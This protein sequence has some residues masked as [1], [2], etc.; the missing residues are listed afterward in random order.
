M[1]LLFFPYFLTNFLPS[2]LRSF[3]SFLLPY[4]L[5]SFFPTYQ[6]IYLSIY[7]SINLSFYLSICLFG[8]VFVHWFLNSITPFRSLVL[9]SIVPP[10]L[11]P[12]MTVSSAH[13]L[14]YK[15]T[16]THKRLSCQQTH[17]NNH[18]WRSEVRYHLPE[19]WVPDF[20]CLFKLSSAL[21]NIKKM[22]VTEKKRMRERMREL[23]REREREWER[24]TEREREWERE[25]NRVAVLSH[26]SIFFKRS[27]SCF[28]SNSN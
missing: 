1:T 14:T 10:S 24:E 18:E 25:I 16:I 11:F 6:S 5:I 26:S 27:L 17:T 12:K 20:T 2:V 19:P 3:A 22:K 7:L 21:K 13:S 8:C 23:H 4:L 15:N 9:N 28:P